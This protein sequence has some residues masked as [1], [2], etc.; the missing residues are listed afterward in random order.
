M[1]L[2]AMSL[3]ATASESPAVEAVIRIRQGLAELQRSGSSNGGG[4]GSSNRELR[5]ALTEACM[6][7]LCPDGDSGCL[8]EHPAVRYLARHISCAS[9][10][11]PFSQRQ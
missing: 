11:V 8:D 6:A 4:A 5:E 1:F 3:K 9:C 2:E 7:A 10:A